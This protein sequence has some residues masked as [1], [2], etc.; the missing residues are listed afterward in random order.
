MT[1]NILK[2]LFFITI[3]FSGNSLYSQKIDSSRTSY[4]GVLFDNPYADQKFNGNWVIKGWDGNDKLFDNELYS[5]LTKVEPYI[6]S[7]MYM[8]IYKYKDSLVILNISH[9]DFAKIVSIPGCAGCSFISHYDLNKDIL[10]TINPAYSSNELTITRNP[11]GNDLSV[12]LGYYVNDTIYKEKNF[13]LENMDKYTSPSFKLKL[14]KK[15]K[16]LKLKDID[17]LEFEYRTGKVFGDSIISNKEYE[18][19]QFN[20]IGTTT[21]GTYR[22]IGLG[23]NSDLKNSILLLRVEGTSQKYFLTMKV[24]RKNGAIEPHVIRFMLNEK[25]EI[26]L[27]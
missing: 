22:E 17:K 23:N 15:T 3:I 25:D 16:S 6:D 8:L 21:K 19:Y 14:P 24:K 13:V 9:Q 4:P 11:N 2:Y 26:T 18:I 1:R 5:G 27:D 7:L 10:Y 20:D 12:K